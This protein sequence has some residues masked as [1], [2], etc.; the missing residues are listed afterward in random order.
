M[1]LPP[2]TKRYIVS[3]VGFGYAVHDTRQEKTYYK[4]VDPSKPSGPKGRIVQIC[5][6]AETAYRIA[7]ELNA[8]ENG[9][10]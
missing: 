7:R 4:D 8:A 10:K 6:N 9:K 1:S 3:N 5:P 2:T